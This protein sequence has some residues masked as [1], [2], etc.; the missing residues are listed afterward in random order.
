MFIAWA[1][2]GVYVA[3]RS[4]NTQ[5]FYDDLH[6]IRTYTPQELLS[7]WSGTWDVDH[8]ET[9]GYR[10]LT[11]LFNHTRALLLG[12]NVLLHRLLIITLFAACLIVLSLIATRF[13]IP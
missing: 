10:P 12:E 13:G 2:W 8:I 11:T 9:P 6:L 5:W 7:T 1:A 3:H 4:I